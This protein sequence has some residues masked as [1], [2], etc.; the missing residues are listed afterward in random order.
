MSAISERKRG[1]AKHALVLGLGAVISA[2]GASA[3]VCNAYNDR[4][5]R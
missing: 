3:L 4:S 5:W 2:M 1:P